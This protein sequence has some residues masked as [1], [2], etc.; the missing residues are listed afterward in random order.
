MRWKWTECAEQLPKKHGKYLVICK[1]FGEPSVDMLWFSSDL[2]QVDKYDF[3]KYKGKK[4]AGWYS[5]DGEYGYSEFD[6]K[7]VLA[8]TKMPKI[9]DE[10]W[11]E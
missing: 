4:H 9:P 10:Y 7:E 3:Q 1:V 8:W 2:Y 5:Y 11:E 6:M